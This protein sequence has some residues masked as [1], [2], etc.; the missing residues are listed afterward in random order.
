LDSAADDPEVPSLRKLIL[1]SASPRR[2]RLLEEAGW[3]VD[4]QPP[5]IDD[6]L[7]PLHAATPEATVAALAWFKAA[8]MALPVGEAVAAIAADTLCVAGNRLLGKPV[9]RNEASAMLR[10]LLSGRHQTLTGVCIRHR[11]GRRQLFVDAATVDMQAPAPEE[12]ESYLD[13]EAWRGKAGGYNL[14]DRQAAGWPIRCFGDPTTVMG[15]PMQRLS[16]ILDALDDP[17]AAG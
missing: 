4:Q 3:A 12:I 16:P 7:L 13:S 14:V 11:D 8:Q 6:G 5:V 9:D 15:L 1:G 10:Q 2:R 17:R